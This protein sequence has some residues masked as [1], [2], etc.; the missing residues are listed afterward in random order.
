LKLHL[1]AGRIRI[2]GWVNVDVEPGSDV[3]ADLSRPF[4]WGDGAATVVFCEH[5]LEHLSLEEGQR[6]LRECWRVLAPRGVLRI[7]TPDLEVVVRDYLEKKLD[8]I[9][10][11]V[12]APATPAQMLNEAMRS[13]GHQFL[14]DRYELAAAMSAAGFASIL[15]EQHRRSSVPHLSGIEQRPDCNETIIFE[16]TKL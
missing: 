6:F 15:E 7:S 9:D 14:Y 11:A 1:G 8:R 12:W 16:G 3:V 4:P 2:P 5:F 13:W 10:R